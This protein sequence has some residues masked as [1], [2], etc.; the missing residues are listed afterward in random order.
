MF[1]SHKIQEYKTKLVFKLN[2]QFLLTQ[3]EHM[4]FK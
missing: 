2:V 1:V 3:F 4:Y